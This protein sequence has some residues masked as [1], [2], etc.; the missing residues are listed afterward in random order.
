MKYL[1]ILMLLILTSCSSQKVALVVETWKPYCGG[2]KPTPEIA[3]GTTSAFKNEKVVL[4]KMN[5]DSK[6]Y[7]LEKWIKLDSTG[8]WTGK[9]KTGSYQVFRGDKMLSIEEI[10][11]KFRKPDTEMYAF[12]GIE[13]L[14]S[15]KKTAD[16]SFEVKDETSVSF[17]LNEKCFV[18]L[19]PC[20]EYIGPKPR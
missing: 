3:K 8:K 10:Q 7:T 11:Q 15:W 20:M 1:S 16:F 9:L 5:V 13:Y 19:N 6:F 12:V 17:T 18:G 4:Y 2:A 14:K